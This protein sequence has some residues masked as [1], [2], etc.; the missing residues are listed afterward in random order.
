MIINSLFN[1]Q[2]FLPHSLLQVL[3]P[4]LDPPPTKSLL[5]VLVRRRVFFLLRTDIDCFTVP[6]VPPGEGMG[7]TPLLH[8]LYGN[9]PLNGV[10]F[11]SSSS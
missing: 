4:F 8:G 5:Y 6:Y 7:Y 11:Y 9:V 3:V 2:K 1:M 10:W